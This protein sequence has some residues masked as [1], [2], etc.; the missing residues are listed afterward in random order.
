MVEHLTKLKIKLLT[1][2]ESQRRVAAA[3][4]MGE[5]QLSKYALGQEP[6]RRHHV[7]ALARYFNCRQTDI[8]GWAQV[9]AEP[10]DEEEWA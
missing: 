6:I 8:V 1:N 4:D 7:K 3:C 9:S 5:A 10:V 2:G